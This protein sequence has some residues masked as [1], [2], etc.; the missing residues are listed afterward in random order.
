MVRVAAITSGRQ[1]PS[2][3]F[4]IR[5]YVEPLQRLGAW[6]HEYSPAIDKWKSLPGKPRNVTN[7]QLLPI[8]TMWQAA[9]L[10]T[11]LPGLVASYRHQVTW[12][13]KELLPGYL[14]LEPLLHR[15]LVFDIDDAVWLTSPF[16]HRA[17]TGIARRSEIVIAGNSFLG[18]RVSTVARDVVVIPTAVDTRVFQPRAQGLRNSEVF[19]V[20]WIGS[21]SNFPFL[22]GIED[23]LYRFL[24]RHNDARVLVVAEE[25]PR[26]QRLAPER[27][28][29]EKWSEERAPALVQDMDVGLMPL[30]DSEWA[31]GKCALKMLQYMACG[32]PVVVSPVGMNKEVLGMADL[33]FGARTPE[34]W[35][36]ALESIYRDQRRGEELGWNGRR[37]AERVFDRDVVARQIADVFRALT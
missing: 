30:I 29:F 20:G 36:D 16:G 3:Q 32:I 8:Y 13:N 18:E 17:V 4:R 11:R 10:A 21:S 1:T 23:A 24:K 19:T 37:I 25:A 22:T 27:V 7:R 28:A 26:F 34:E 35:D 15:P 9:K 14:T 2:A 12:L 5:Q 33:G 31:R 6:V